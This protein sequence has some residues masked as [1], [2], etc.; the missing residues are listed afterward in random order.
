MSRKRGFIRPEDN[1]EL[2]QFTSA[3]GLP[4]YGEEQHARAVKR[5]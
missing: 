4:D 1:E 5:H 2:E 3:W